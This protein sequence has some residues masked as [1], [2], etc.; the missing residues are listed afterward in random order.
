MQ[1][2]AIESSAWIFFKVGSSFVIFSA[3]FFPTLS[4]PAICSL[5]SLQHPPSHCLLSRS[6]WSNQLKPHSP[7]PLNSSPDH[8]K[9]L[10]VITP[11]H[12]FS[13]QHSFPTTILSSLSP[14]C[15]PKIPSQ[16]H[17]SP[18][19]GNLLLFRSWQFTCP[20]PTSP[21]FPPIPMIFSPY[22]RFKSSGPIS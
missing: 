18:A 20:L 17:Q 3:T 22:L 11:I 6:Q 10:P 5:S 2:I 8:S 4:V 7:N 16:P 15:P 19:I 1:D 14:Y 21:S 12:L 13:K 9:P